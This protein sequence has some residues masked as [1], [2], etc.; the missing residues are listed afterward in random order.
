M[1]VSA[2]T[3]SNQNASVERASRQN[4]GI[5]KKEKKQSFYDEYKKPAAYA[6]GALAAGLGIFYYIK[7]RRAPSL[8]KEISSAA[9]NV[10]ENKLPLK[11]LTC[12]MSG[13]E[14]LKELPKLTKENFVC[15]P[16]NM[17]NG[18]FRADLHSHSNYS[19]GEGYVKNILEEAAEYAD[20]LYQK[21]GQKFIFALTDHDTVDG[22]KEAFKIISQNPSKYKNLQ[23]VPG[24]EISFA[25]SAPKST[26]ECE[27][28]EVLAYGINPFSENIGKFFEN[29][30][31]KRLQMINNFINEA[32]EKCPLT[33]FSFD[34]FSKYYEHKK[35]G[36]LMNIHWRIYHY[37]QTKHALTRHAAN[38]NQDAE[39]LYKNI[40]E[41]F[42]GASVETLKT[43]GK[44]PFSINEVSD[45]D[46]IL[47]KYS[48]HFENGKLVAASENSFEEI[49]ENLKE[50]K[51]IFLSFAHPGYF[52]NHVENAGES[53]KYFTE[54][55]KGLIKASE[56][57]HQAYKEN[58]DKNF[59]ERLREKTES[60]NLLNLGGRDNHGKK[61]F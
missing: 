49:I 37:V 45:F 56:S 12:I 55:S 21:T 22:V 52:A 50:E 2:I 5:R 15:T 40:M 26:N 28:S 13:D 61:L 14:L 19:D 38:I 23:F 54:N 36:N 53:L 33:K 51:N 11:N 16:E 27:M 44:I 3:F 41:N 60:L 32:G 24:V 39:I 48:P 9:N 7:S 43:N 17:K 35:Y 18:I 20:K 31:Q 42:K 46:G 10:S 57:Y 34:E 47:K 8:A 58:V 25:H 29:I 4:T 59:I 1:K 6:A 30:K